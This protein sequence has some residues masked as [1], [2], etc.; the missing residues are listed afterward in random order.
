MS[1]KLEYL[2]T[3]ERY[4]ILWSLP[5]AFFVGLSMVKIIFTPCQ[6]LWMKP[7]RRYSSQIGGR[8]HWSLA[9]LNW[10]GKLALELLAI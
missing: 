1:N 5:G 3:N 7:K 2:L 9:S 6:K 8:F 4:E 10:P